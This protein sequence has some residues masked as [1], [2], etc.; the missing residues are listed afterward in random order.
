MIISEQETL[1][2]EFLSFNEKLLITKYELIGKPKVSRPVDLSEQV[3]KYVPAGELSGRI[4]K[5]PQ[6][7]PKIKYVKPR[8]KPP[9]GPSER[10]DAENGFLLENP[11][12]ED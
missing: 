1:C 7:G 5:D 6:T 12:T 2:F 9:M 8:S 3:R 4:L 11:V 10:K